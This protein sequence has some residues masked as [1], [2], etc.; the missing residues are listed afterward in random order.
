M[1]SPEYAAAMSLRHSLL[2]LLWMQPS[3]GYQ[4]ASRFDASLGHAWHATH[5]QIYPELARMHELGF[6]EVVGEGA[7]NRRTWAATEAGREELR[8]WLKDVEPNRG[9]R[10]EAG[11]RGFVVFLLDPEERR[12]LFE[13][14]LEV[15]DELQ[16]TLDATQQRI[17]EVGGSPFA[18]VVD[19][20]QRL[21][22]VM[23][24]WL[25]EQIA[26]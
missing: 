24:E 2:G 17:D 9:V 4:L 12:P 14:E 10:N 3:S 8:H 13:R 21:N 1:S 16:A 6:I 22:A 19:L 7:R 18:P 25:A 20:G 15:A 26:R 23:R 11:V 5:S